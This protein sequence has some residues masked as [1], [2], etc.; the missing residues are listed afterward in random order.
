MKERGF[1]DLRIDTKRVPTWIIA[2]CCRALY[3]LE[4]V[5]P[6]SGGLYI[7]TLSVTGTI[8]L[9]IT[10]CAWHAISMHEIGG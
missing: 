10:W 3:L 6:V 4:S 7:R 5:P 9:R 2:I 1:D 8:R